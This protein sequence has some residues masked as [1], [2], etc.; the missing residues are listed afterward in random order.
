MVLATY[1]LQLCCSASGSSASQDVIVYLTASDFIAVI[2]LAS[3]E[4][5]DKLEKPAMSPKPE[6]V[7]RAAVAVGL[8]PQSHC[9]YLAAAMRR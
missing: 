7:P 3:L 6:I 5:R 1:L 8:A 9:Y 4:L 2:L